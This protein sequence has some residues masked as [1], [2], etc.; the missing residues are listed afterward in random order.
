MMP[1]RGQAARSA[2]RPGQLDGAI[3][4]IGLSCRLPAA[5]EPRS[6]WRMLRDGVHGITEVPGGRPDAAVLLA[7]GIRYGAFLSGVEEF[8]PEFFGISPREAASMD[9]QQRLML[10][11]AW[12]AL[13]HA[14]IPPP[15]LRGTPSGVFVGAISDDYAILERRGG[16][17]AIT[18]YTMTGTHRAII[19]NRISYLLGLTGPSL[20]VDSAQS[21][22]LV[23]V[24]LACESLRR[25]EATLALAGGVSLALAAEPAVSAARIGALSPDGRC[26]VFDSRANGYVRGEGGGLVVLKPLAAAV[27]DGDPVR[28]VIL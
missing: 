23:S 8:D 18:H 27:R 1:F 21:S 4:I 2:P 3:A 14:S 17:Q 9:P 7:E 11:L 25:G 28:S 6:F 10:E 26:Y 19:A 24:Q 22:S 20:I 5:P 13:E 15:T 12:E 16:G